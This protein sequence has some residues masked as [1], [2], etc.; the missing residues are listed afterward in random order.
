MNAPILEA[1][2][3]CRAYPVAEEPV[4]ALRSV[5]LTLHRGDFVA[6]MGP[7]GCGK[8]TLL[9]LCGAMDRPD[10]GNLWIE[11]RDVA[12]LSDGDLTKLRRE[13]VGFV[14]QFFNLLPTL[15]VLENIAMPLLLARRPEAEAN[16][17]AR[18]LAE[19]VGI[20]HRLSHFPAQISGG[21]AQRAAVARAVVHEP[22]LLIAD[23]P[24]G[25]LD[26]S[27]GQG[28][29]ELLTE[30]NRDLKIAILMATHDAQ[31]AAAAQTMIQ[32]KDGRI[33]M[34]S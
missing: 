11:G 10:S 33:L 21:E 23:E 5:S 31:V 29:L 14:F 24:T 25:S 15:T 19:R 1:T 6:V 13:R 32:M 7:S 2:N 30:L 17:Q 34:E 4:S 22:A 20:A 9:Q 28:I 27:N 3:L 8:S 26:S 16:A 18:V 12:T